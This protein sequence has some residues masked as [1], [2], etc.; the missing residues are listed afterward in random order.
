MGAADDDASDRATMADVSHRNPYTGDTM[1]AVFRRGPAV[2]DGGVA[3][4]SGPDRGTEP[5]ETD[6]RTA[7]REI[8]HTPRNDDVNA[9]WARGGRAAGP[10]GSETGSSV[11]GVPGDD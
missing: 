5:S 8:D 4:G 1:G 6:D 10:S 7:M 2:A 11:S 3:D 9:V